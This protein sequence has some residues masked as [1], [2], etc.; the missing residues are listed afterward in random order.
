[1]AIVAI[2][3]A[4]DPSPALESN[5]TFLPN[6]EAAFRMGRIRAFILVELF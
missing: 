4:F 5:W 6:E 2:N 3:P 1:M